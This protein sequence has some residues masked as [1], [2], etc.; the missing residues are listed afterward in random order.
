M[1]IPA[2][3]LLLSVLASPGNGASGLA[4]DWQ[5]S[6]QADEWDI[7]Y[8]PGM[9]EHPERDGKGWRFSF[10]QYDGALPCGVICPSVG[11]VTT[12][13]A[14]PLNGLSIAI[15]VEITGPGIFEYR[16]DPDNTCWRPAAVR[17]FIQ[18][19]DDDDSQDSYRWW[20]NPA[21]INLRQGD[22][23]L[24][25]PLTPDQWSNVLGEKGDVVRE[26][27]YAALENVESIGMT[28]GGGCFFGHGVN[29]SG[30]PATFVVKKLEI[31]R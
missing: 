31:L 28:F 14:A 8:S 25:V 16:L 3:I 15:T 1:K 18:R 26:E 29:V 17:L 13:A 24:D 7:R 2:T 5:P 11:Y 22:H 19:R 20:S 12:R 23:S 10:P 4:P 30:G 21:A 9:P 6:T 27:F